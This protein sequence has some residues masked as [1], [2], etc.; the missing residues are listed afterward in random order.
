MGIYIYLKICR[1]ASN[2]ALVLGAE[3][4]QQRNERHHVRSG[5]KNFRSI[6]LGIFTH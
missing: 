6:V 3:T 4:H 5:S 1:T 2:I